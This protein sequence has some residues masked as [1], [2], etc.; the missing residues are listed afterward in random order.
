MALHDFMRIFNFVKIKEY[1]PRGRLRMAR[2]LQMH[3]HKSSQKRIQQLEKHKNRDILCQVYSLLYL[4]WVTPSLTLFPDLFLYWQ[5]PRGRCISG[6]ESSF[7]SGR[8]FHHIYYACVS[9]KRRGCNGKNCITIDSQSRTLEEVA[10]WLQFWAGK[11][12]IGQ[13]TV[14]SLWG[15]W[16]LSVITLSE[17]CILPPSMLPWIINNSETKPFQTHFVPPSDEQGY[18]DRCSTEELL[19]SQLLTMRCRKALSIQAPGSAT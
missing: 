7:S 19:P 18:T 1:I 11:N 2:G 17:S 16:G 13:T 9:V 14:V 15:S 6:K 8:H 5:R 4:N 12:T 10:K 3:C